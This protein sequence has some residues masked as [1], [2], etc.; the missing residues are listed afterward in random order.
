MDLTVSEQQDVTVIS[1]QG[2]I[3]GGPDATALNDKLHEMIEGGKK[4][5]VVDLDQ[6]KIMNSSGLGMLIGG[7]TTMRNVG[8]DLKIARASQKISGLITVAKLGSI[9][10]NF[11][12]VGEAVDDFNR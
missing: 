4:K 11:P 2:N 10:P 1:L 3:M 12:S 6:V 8:G 5:I 9:F 7:L